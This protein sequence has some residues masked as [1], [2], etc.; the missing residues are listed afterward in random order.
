[1]GPDQ[2]CSER[3]IPPHLHRCEREPVEQFDAEELL[4]RRYNKDQIQNDIALAISFDRSSS[5]LTRS[6]F[7]SADDARWDGETGRYHDQCGV[8][9]IPAAAFQ[10]QS[11]KVRDLAVAVQVTPFHDPLQCMFPHCDLRVVEGG[12]EIMRIKQKSIKMEI[13]DLLRPLIRI[14]PQA[15]LG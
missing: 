1:M 10:G 9:S 6:K 3:G 13:R 2:L 15:P 5:S 4:F 12:K 14:E 8:I 11:W 7:G